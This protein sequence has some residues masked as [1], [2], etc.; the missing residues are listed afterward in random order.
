MKLGRGGECLIW[1]KLSNSWPLQICFIL[2]G[3]HLWLITSWKCVEQKYLKYGV[4]SNSSSKLCC[5]PCNSGYSWHH[6]MVH[7]SFY[8]WEIMHATIKKMNKH[9][10]K[11][12][13]EVEEAKDSLEAAQRKVRSILIRFHLSCRSVWQP[14]SLC[15]PRFWSNVLIKWPNGLTSSLLIMLIILKSRSERK[16]FSW[17]QR[18]RWFWS[19]FSSN[20][21][22]HQASFS[23][24]NTTYVGI[25][26][27]WLRC[28][29]S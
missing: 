9:V 22:S 25:V 6:L 21:Y 27:A 5:L 24:L 28:T 20:F 17:L 4:R 23:E 13:K 10:A 12:Q 1:K 2:F 11:L 26:N 16:E 7:S 3:F 18:F 8:V 15:P 14:R 19:S 29:K